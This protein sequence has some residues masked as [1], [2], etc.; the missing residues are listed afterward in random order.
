MK[1]ILK[2]HRKASVILEN[3]NL[4]A[5]LNIRFNNAMDRKNALELCA[6]ITTEVARAEAKKA[7]KSRKT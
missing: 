1:T 5:S 3:G 4:I 2:Q 7:A 6:I